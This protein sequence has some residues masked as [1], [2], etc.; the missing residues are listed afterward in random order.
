MAISRRKFIKNGTLVALVAGLPLK[1]AAET[2]NPGTFLAAGAIGPI[3]S[4]G[5]KLDLN[6]FSTYLKSDFQLSGPGVP[7]I[8]ARLIEVHDWKSQAKAPEHLKTKECF[9]AIFVASASAP[10]P[11]DT[12]TVEHAALGKFSMFLVPSRKSTNGIQ[13]EAVFNRL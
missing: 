3:T 1:V 2:I 7:T 13:Y 6:S 4:N 8:R 5:S 12:Y 9:S 10:L 11:Q